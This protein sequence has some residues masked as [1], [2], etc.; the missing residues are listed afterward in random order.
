MSKR[1]FFIDTDTAPTM[2]SLSMALQ[3][4]DV[5]VLGIS[6]VA[7]NCTIEQAMNALHTGPCRVD[8]PGSRRRQRPADVP[9]QTAYHVHARTAGDIGLPTAV[10]SPSPSV[11]A[12]IDAIMNSPGDVELVRRGFD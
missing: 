5:D 6:T 3:H 8:G 7:G 9:L 4:P 12:M 10:V 11:Q 1:K 2:R